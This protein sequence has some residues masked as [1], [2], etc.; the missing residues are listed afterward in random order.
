MKKAIL[1]AAAM[2]LIAVQVAVA[3][4][5]LAAGKND[6][7][8]IGYV[9][10]QRALNDCNEG[11]A[12]KVE[13]QAEMK[14]MQ[15]NI[16]KKIA[17]RDKLKAELERQSSVL[18]PKAKKAKEATLEKLTADTQQLITES[19]QDMQQKQREKEVVILKR[20]KAAIDQIGKKDHYM[21]ILPSDVILYSNGAKE[22]TDDV[23]QTVNQM[24]SA[25]AQAP[26][27]TGK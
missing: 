6:K 27:K 4:P 13:L 8:K 5:A 9:D 20:I 14:G 15:A 26:A 12:A 23:I 16:D 7:D 3:Q 1:M 2:L 17:E 25:P 24:P 21:V 18:S 11:K 19:N 10:L 22:I